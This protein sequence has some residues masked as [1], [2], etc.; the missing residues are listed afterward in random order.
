MTKILE[1]TYFSFY[2][3]VSTIEYSLQRCCI[4]MRIKVELILHHQYSKRN[5]SGTENILE[6]I[7]FRPLHTKIK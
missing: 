2:F 5:N 4:M 6:K 7:S 3:T 1:K